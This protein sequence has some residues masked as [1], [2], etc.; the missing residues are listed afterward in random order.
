VGNVREDNLEELW[1]H[2][3]VFED[4]RNKD[5][6]EGCGN[7]SYRYVCGGCRARAYNYFGDYL[8]PDPGCVNNRKWWE[9]IKEYERIS[10]EPKRCC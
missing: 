6:L 3:H 10:G 7:C 8:K 1:L 4:L 2:N 5:L 9:R